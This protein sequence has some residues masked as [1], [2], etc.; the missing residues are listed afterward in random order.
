MLEVLWKVFL[1]MWL[2]IQTVT[3]VWSQAVRSQAVHSHAV[4]SQAVHSHAVQLWTTPLLLWRL[5]ICRSQR[6]LAGQTPVWQR[7]GIVPLWSALEQPLLES[8]A[9]FWVPP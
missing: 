2:F 9:K 3:T 4:Q 7:E 5:E 1:L 6:V 8:C